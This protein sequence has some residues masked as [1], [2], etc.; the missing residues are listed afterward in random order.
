MNNKKCIHLTIRKEI[1]D[2]D[3]EFNMEGNN[4]E[5]KQIKRK[6]ETGRNKH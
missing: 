5:K 3:R 4:T 2:R 6:N 1:K